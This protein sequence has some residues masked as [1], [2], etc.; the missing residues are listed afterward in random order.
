MTP[1]SQSSRNTHCVVLPE[2][3]N[4]LD[5]ISSL[6]QN[7]LSIGIPAMDKEPMSMTVEVTFMCF[8][9]PPISFSSSVWT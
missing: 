6:D 4:T 2:A 7:P 9:N 1:M 8:L 5:N 3:L